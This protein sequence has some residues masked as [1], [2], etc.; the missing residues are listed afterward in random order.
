MLTHQVDR[1]TA[2]AAIRSVA[3]L[4]CIFLSGCGSTGARIWSP[5]EHSQLPGT[6]VLAAGDELE[7]MCLGAPDL[8]TSQSIRRDGKITLG[9]IGDFDAAGK[10]VDALRK[11]ITALYA[12]Q[13]QVKET[14]V[15][16]RSTAP[17]FVS[18]AVQTPGRVSA[19]YPITVLEAIVEAGGFFENEAHMSNVVV[20]RHRH[21]RRRGFALD[22]R[23]ALRGEQTTVFYLQPFDIVYVPRTRITR[24]NQWIEQHINRIIPRLGVGVSSSGDLF[25]SF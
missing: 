15:V 14:S 1:S 2:T 21:G 16:V 11:E 19:S 9:L 12:K 3:V 23:P 10:T 24:V 13:L 18:G 7:I 20:I 17:V 25:Y 4:L 5:A 6:M 22:L 8:N